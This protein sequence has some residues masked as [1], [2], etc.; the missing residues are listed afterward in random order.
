M[1]R[2][3]PVAVKMSF[4]IEENDIASP[5]NSFPRQ[6][7]RREPT[8]CRSA[9]GRPFHNP[10]EIADAELAENRHPGSSIFADFRHS[11]NE[12]GKVGARRR[13]VRASANASASSNII[14][15]IHE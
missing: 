5:Q 9:I 3:L 15:L 14:H 2:L 1:S 13:Q 7:D 12:N 11:Q 6:G 4:Y 8:P 10:S